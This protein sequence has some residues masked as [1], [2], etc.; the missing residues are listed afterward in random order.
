MSK[1]KGNVVRPQDVIEKYG[2][3]A[4]RF[5]A[6]GSKLGEDLPYQEKD[7]VTGKKMVTKLWNASKFVLMHLED[8]DIKKKPKLEVMDRWLIS[9]LNKVI[10]E[11]TDSFE[12]YE[13]ARTK[14]HTELFFW[15]TFCDNYLEI[16]KDR[17]YNPDRRGVDKREA[18]Q[19]ALYTALL[20]VIKLMAPI[21]PFI[22]EGVYQQYFAEEE[23][24]KSIHISKWPESDVGLIDEEA[25]KAGDLAVEV[26]GAVRKQK[27]ENNVSL[28]TEL[29]DLV[30][31]CDKD[32]QKLLELVKEDLLACTKAN[33][34]SY[35]EGEFAVEIELKEE[36]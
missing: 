10:I 19:Y 18:A 12:E 29:N 30:V 28:K 14:S 36:K 6:A 1:S 7:I 3:D 25:E 4:M 34:I 13:Y 9:K 31:T 35:K 23:K 20:N 21:M 17:M 32:G 27:S 16:V 22:T 2:A 26:I 5:W 8:F 24:C 15:Q 33:K 11:S